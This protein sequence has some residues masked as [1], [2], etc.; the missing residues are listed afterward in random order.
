MAIFDPH[1]QRLCVRVVYDGIAGAGK[2]TNLRQLAALFAAQRATE[3]WSASELAGRTLYFDWMQLNAG[4]VAGIPLLCQIIS[5]PGQ[6]A[7]TPRRLHLLK[8]ADVVVYVCDSDASSVGRARESLAVVDSILRDGGEKLPFV[9]Q[10]NKQDQHDA[11]DG[12][13]LLAALGRHDATVVDAIAT[14]GIGVVDTFVS[15]VRILSRTM[16]ARTDRGALHVEVRRVETK[17]AALADIETLAIDPEAAAEM[18]L[19]EAAASLLLADVVEHLDGGPTPP[20]PADASSTVAKLP[21][22]PH[23]GV[24]TGFIWPAHTGRTILRTL[25][26]TGALAATPKAN[27]QGVVSHAAC[28]WTLRTDRSRRFDTAESAQQALVRAARHRTQLD[29]LLVPDTVVVAQSSDDR[30]WSLWTVMPELSSFAATLT[31][32]GPEDD[33]TRHAWLDAYGAALV[34]AVRASLRHG[35]GLELGPDRFGVDGRLLRYVG[36]ITEPRS[37]SELASAVVDAIVALGQSPADIDVVL[38]AFD[39][40]IQRRLTHEERAST[41]AVVSATRA[42]ATAGPSDA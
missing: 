23:A 11:L 31:N 36:D 22:L 25:A 16:Q 17:E 6:V 12:A 9:I 26:G 34:D 10:A 24:P 35:F 21:V 29:Q 33:E 7:L 37:P 41:A 19:E 39:R 14:D 32:L 5:V 8:Q 15:A 27:A 38:A 13:S 42:L 18:L 30:T 40:E 2:T 1:E 20:R 4:V 3:V 28:G